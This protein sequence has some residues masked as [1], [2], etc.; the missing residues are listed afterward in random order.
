MDCTQCRKYAGCKEAC[1][2]LEYDLLSLDSNDYCLYGLPPE[3]LK[4]DYKAVLNE[5][6]ESGQWRSRINIENIWLIK[7]IKQRAIAV[8]LYGEINV[9]QISEILKLSPSQ[10]YRIAGKGKRCLHILSAD[11]DLPVLVAAT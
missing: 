11:L 9:K 5:M 2:W 8:M 6:A 7:D 4:I 10:I 1:I 3:A